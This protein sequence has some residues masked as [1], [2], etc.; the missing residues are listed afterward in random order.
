MRTFNTTQDSK[1]MY[2]FIQKEANTKKII[3][4]LFI[5]LFI[6]LKFFSN[7]NLETVGLVIFPSIMIFLYKKKGIVYNLLYSITTMI[8]AFLFWGKYSTQDIIASLIG[9]C[10]AFAISTSIYFIYKRQ[11]P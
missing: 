7:L 6:I 11:T 3:S 5:I 8:I 1:G 2:S 10:L 9:G 4:L